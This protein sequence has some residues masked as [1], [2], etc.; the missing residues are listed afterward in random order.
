MPMTNK[1][2]DN[3]YF[4]SELEKLERGCESTFD[5]IEAIIGPPP[6]TS[7]ARI[8]DM[9]SKFARGRN[10]GRFGGQITTGDSVFIAAFMATLRPARMIELGVCSGQSS[11]FILVVADRLGLSQADETFLDSIDAVSQFGDD[12]LEVGR[13]VRLNFPLRLPNWSLRT[14]ETII[15]ATA[16]GHVLN[17]I[18]QSAPPGLAMIDAEH[19]HPWPLVDLFALSLALPQNSWILM[20]DIQLTERWLANTIER[21]VICPKPQRGV[22]FAFNH[23]PGSKIAGVDMCYN[24]GAVKNNITAKQRRKFVEEVARYPWEMPRSSHEEL[25]KSLDTLHR[26]NDSL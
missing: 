14:D 25:E 7:R 16:D 21:G 19:Q 6:S 24:M 3:I 18:F 20:Q 13:V 22:A 26:K 1:L 9:S 15:E 2:L 8:L 4:G 17:E 10:S 23:W 11:A 12:A 5:L